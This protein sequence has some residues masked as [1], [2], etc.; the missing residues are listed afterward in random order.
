ML[1]TFNYILKLQMII[2]YNTKSYKV[3]FDIF[4][5]NDNNFML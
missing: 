4:I 1:L 5:K 2:T 3:I